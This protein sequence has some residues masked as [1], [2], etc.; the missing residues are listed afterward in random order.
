[1]KENASP[2]IIINL[3]CFMYVS[4]VHGREIRFNPEEVSVRHWC[5]RDCRQSHT[6]T[7]LAVALMSRLSLFPAT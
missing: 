7:Y 4:V 2:V 3:F 6:L 5:V 1:M